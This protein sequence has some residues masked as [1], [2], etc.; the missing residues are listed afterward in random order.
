MVAAHKFFEGNFCRKLYWSQFAKK[1]PKS[2]AIAG[3]AHPSTEPI[4]LLLF[5]FSYFTGC[6]DLIPPCDF[7]I[8]TLTFYYIWVSFFETGLFQGNKK[9]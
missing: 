7:S 1:I 5:K 8:F 3:L 6:S 4:L 2:G 9:C